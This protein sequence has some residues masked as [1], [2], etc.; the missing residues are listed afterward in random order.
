PGTQKR[1]PAGLAE[2]QNVLEQVPPLEAPP[3]RTMAVQQ[4]IKGLA[5]GPPTSRAVWA[6]LE[7]PITATAAPTSTT[8]LPTTA[9]GS[10]NSRV[11]A[12]ALGSCRVQSHVLS[13]PCFFQVRTCT[14]S[15]PLHRRGRSV[16]PGPAPQRRGRGA[17]GAPR[18][19]RRADP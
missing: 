15:G 2:R 19:G 14:A 11:D 7:S 9:H 13:F 17:Q 12:R 4:L 6:A 8:T 3:Y 18:E 5:W 1:R 10:G 16:C